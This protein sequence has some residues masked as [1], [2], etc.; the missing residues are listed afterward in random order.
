VSIQDERE[1]RDRLGTL[2]DDIEPAPAPV[3]RAMRQGRGIRVRRRVAVALSLAV[4]AGGVA[5]LPVILANARPVP[6]PA[7]PLHFSVTVHSPGN[8][9]RPGLIAWGTQDGH[10]WQITLSGHGKALT[11]GATDAS[12][13]AL[14]GIPLTGQPASIEESGSGRSG[15]LMLVGPVRA[16]VTRMVVELPGKALTL[17]PVR[18]R[19]EDYVGLELPGGVPILRA[20]VYHDGQEIAYSVPYRGTTLAAWWQ[21]GQAGPAG[22]TKTI[23][24][25]VIG[26][27]KWSFAAQFGPWGY[28]YVTPSGSSC[29]S[30]PSPTGG[31]V[32]GPNT[33][34]EMFCFSG[35][36][37]PDVLA[38]AGT[39]VR[40]V[41]VRLP[42]GSAQRYGTVAIPGGR[43]VAYL[44]P[45][46]GPYQILTYNAAGQLLNTVRVSGGGC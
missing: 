42:D 39:Q 11:V 21:P 37:G 40:S 25:G 30:G 26:G 24:S 31:T 18:Y 14:S 41:A 7:G 36:R 32:A 1:L 43:V 13:V 5:A 34:K 2:L 12:F 23:A 33:V 6:R 19:G 29:M 22:F 16:D 10:R 45:A 8:N 4:L 17:T 27:H 35:A 15:P 44:V 9:A 38:A 46:S 28:C 20:T 3:G